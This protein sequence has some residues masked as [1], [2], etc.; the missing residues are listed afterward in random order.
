MFGLPFSPA[1]EKQAQPVATA[2]GPK[3]PWL[4]S[5]VSQR[6]MESP[7]YPYATLEKEGFQLVA[8]ER[9]DAARVLAAPLP[10][11]EERLAAKPG[12]VVKLIFEYRDADERKNGAVVGAEHMWVAVVDYGD[13]CLIGRLDSSPQHTKLL[14]ADDAVA[15]H[16]KHII[17]FWRDETRG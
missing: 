2:N 13:G 6:K 14:K 8:I 4:I 10:S 1:D 15:F 9:G 5:N 7:Y 17:A 12:D 16:P 11:E 3:R